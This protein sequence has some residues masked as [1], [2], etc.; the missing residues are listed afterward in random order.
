VS[1]FVPRRQFGT[2]KSVQVCNHSAREATVLPVQAHDRSDLT[3]GEALRATIN[4]DEFLPCRSK[5]NLIATRRQWLVPSRRPESQAGDGGIYTADT[6]ARSKYVYIRSS[7]SRDAFTTR[8][9][10]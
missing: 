7:Q 4:A 1:H 2:L 8:I 10:I 3:C 9:S 6:R 5:E